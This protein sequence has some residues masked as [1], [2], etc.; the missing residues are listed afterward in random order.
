MALECL[1]S[2]PVLTS[3][4]QQPGPSPYRLWPSWPL[5]RT[6]CQPTLLQQHRAPELSQSSLHFKASLSNL[7]PDTFQPWAP[8]SPHQTGRFPNTPLTVL[9]PLAYLSP[10]PGLPSVFTSKSVLIFFIADAG[11]L[12]RKHTTPRFAFPV[13]S[14][15]PPEE[16]CSHVIASVSG[17]GPCLSPPFPQ[18]PSTMAGTQ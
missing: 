12:S 13:P 6:P 8:C 1:L 18:V 9:R 17:L 15:L 2:H 16:P 3:P 14:Y 11:F 4:R 7:V 10:L 5:P